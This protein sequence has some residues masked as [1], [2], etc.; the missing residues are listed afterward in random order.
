[1]RSAPGFWMP[2]TANRHFQARPRML[3]SAEGMYYHS[4]DGRRILDGTAGLWCVNAGHARAEITAAVQRQLATLDFAPTFQMGHPFAEQLAARLAAAAPPGLA[5]VFFTNSGSEAA[6][7]A[8]KIALACHQR[9]GETTRTVLIGRERAYHGVGFGGM[10]VGGIAKNRESWRHSLLPDTDHLRHTHDPARNAFAR[11]QPEHGAEFADDL[12]RL[13]ARHGAGRIAAVIVEPVAGSTGVLVPPQGYLERLRTLC[14]R[15]G[16][17]LILDEVITGFGRT[18]SMF[19]AQQF[20]V[21]ADLITCAKGLTNGAIP[22]GAVLVS[23]A[24]FDT[25]MQGPLPEIDLFHGYTYS[26]HPV[27]CAA[28]LAALDIHEHEQLPQRAARLAPHLADAAHALRGLP[29]VVDVRNY[30]LIAAVEFANEP[31]RAPTRAF[32]VFQRCFEQG[33]LV[34]ATGDVIALSP[35]LIVTEAQIAEMFTTLAAAIRA[36]PVR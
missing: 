3:V 15:H 30:G 32:D 21:R 33:L 20:G 36:T 29:G 34:R 25:F 6:D 16:L 4:A 7:T 9:R 28:A 17:L 31:G 2:F 22:M 24:V 35:P 13:I 1:M 10:S 18:G 23:D 14:D 5:H 12:E 27:A 11:G 26:G 19:A 8:L